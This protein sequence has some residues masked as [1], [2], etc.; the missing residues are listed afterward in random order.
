MQNDEKLSG[1]AGTPYYL[2]PEVISNN[3]TEKCDIWSIGVILYVLL[4]GYPPFEGDTDDDI[5]EKVKEGKYSM[6]GHGW[7]II[8]D[9][10]KNLIRKMICYD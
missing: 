7:D 9:S 6:V 3:Y 2:A 8:S 1:L 4:A 5:I 10:A